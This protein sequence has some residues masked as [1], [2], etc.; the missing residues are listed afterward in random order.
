MSNALAPAPASAPVPVPA[1]GGGLTS[2]NVR[3][4]V[5]TRPKGTPGK[6]LFQMK[7]VL[8]VNSPTY[9]SVI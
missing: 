6:G 8:K 7:K 5:C 1:P 4:H 2:L 3:F 9:A